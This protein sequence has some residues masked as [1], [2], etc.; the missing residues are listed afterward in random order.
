MAPKLQIKRGLKKDLPTLASGE[1]GLCE[2]TGELFVGT[3]SGNLP[4]VSAAGAGDMLKSVYDADNDGVVDKAESVSWAGVTGKPAT[5]APSSH[6]HDDRY[7]TESEMN[8]KLDGKANTSGTYAG[9]TAGDAQK[10]IGK[11]WNWSGQS[12]QPSWLWGG[13]DGTNM[14]VYNP[15]N[16]NVNYA[17]SAGAVAWSNVSGKPST[18]APASHTHTASQVGLGSVSNAA[19]SQ[20]SWWHWSGQGG[21][22]SWLWGG[23]SENAYYLYNPSNFNVNYASSSG[24]ADWAKSAALTNN[25]Y[26]LNFGGTYLSKWSSENILHIR[27]GTIYCNNNNNSGW[28]PIYASAFTQQSS[29][30]YKENIVPLAETEAHALLALEP[31]KY[32]YINRID[33]TGRYGLIAEDAYAVQ[34]QGVVLKEMDGEVVPDGIDYASYVPQLI[35]LCQLQQT[36]L[37]QQAEQLQTLTKQLEGLEALL[38]EA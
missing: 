7:Y 16:F 6:T 29:R 20:K 3:Q 13:S 2:D 14:Y 31:V 18:F 32:D 26:D 28:I 15:S 33:G 34:P 27:T 36:Q 24:T 12:G 35:K 17:N 37:D 8:T 1:F 22:P 4:V 9:I 5:F 11:T 30:R 23:N 38:K 25:V 19:Q 21:Q 10:L